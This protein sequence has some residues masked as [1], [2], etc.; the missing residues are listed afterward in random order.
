M[1]STE[2]TQPTATTCR[3]PLRP[4]RTVEGVRAN[5]G[6]LLPNGCV[7]QEQIGCDAT[8]VVP[9]AVMVANVDTRF[10][11]RARCAGEDQ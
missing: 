8:C 6:C 9:N 3:D 1:R 7:L 4:G 2:R 10:G 11:R 5:A